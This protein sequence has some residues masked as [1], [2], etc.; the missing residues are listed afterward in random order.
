M[1]MMIHGHK[2]LAYLL[3]L[4]VTLCLILAFTG[5]SSK[6]GSARILNVINRFGVMMLGRINLVL[7]IALMISLG[8]SV[9]QLWIIASVLIWGAVEMARPRFIAPA[10][11]RVTEGGKAGSGLLIGVLVQVVAVVAIFGLMTVRP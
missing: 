9:L 8:T 3:C 10:L 11:A 7:G 2:G 6:P 4:A 5:A 1:N